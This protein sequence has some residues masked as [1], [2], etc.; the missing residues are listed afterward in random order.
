MNKIDQQLEKIKK[1]N[2]IGLM[3]HVVVGYPSLEETVSLVKTMA[4]SG[5]DFIELQIPFSDPLADGPTIMKACED[6]LA[7]GT[8]VKDAFSIMRQLS[9]EI[10]V[11][12]LFMSYYNILFRYGVE[13]FCKDAKA[14]GASGLIIP[15][16][17][18]DEEPY[19]HFYESAKKYDLYPISVV[20]PA[21]T[22][23]RLRKNAAIAK[24]FI[25]CTARQG[26]TG[27]KKELDPTI[28]SYLNNVKKYFSIPLA[29]GFG[30]SKKEQIAVLQN[31][32][33]AA[34][35]GSALIDL[36]NKTEKKERQETVKKFII[37]LIH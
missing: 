36:I 21:S 17:P 1:V 24:G 9:A 19:E 15:D 35:I 16:M 18:I 22:P 31:H 7:N 28:R 12:L 2:K 34:I 13:K 10:S 30:I 33:E 6:S 26:T 3:T 11:P 29:V 37:E 32:A 14:A 5:V 20:S 4:A 23:E 25:Y 27:A 8:R